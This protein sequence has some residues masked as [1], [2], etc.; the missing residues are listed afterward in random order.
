[1]D[2]YFYCMKQGW[3]KSHEYYLRVYIYSIL[4]NAH[5]VETDSMKILIEK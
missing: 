1:M 2:E 3:K 5:S 4:E